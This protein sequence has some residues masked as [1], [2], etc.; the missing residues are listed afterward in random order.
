MVSRCP[1]ACSECLCAFEDFSSDMDVE[2]SIGKS[3][4]LKVLFGTGGKTVVF[5]CFVASRPCQWKQRDEHL[6]VGA[7]KSGINCN[8]DEVE[9]TRNRVPEII[10]KPD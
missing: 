9:E 8:R 6:S 5:K 3:C 4:L 1:P 7:L 2:M 10:K